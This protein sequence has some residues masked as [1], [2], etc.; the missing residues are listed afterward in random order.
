VA[1]SGL[2]ALIGVIAIGACLAGAAY[3]ATRHQTGGGGPDRKA[4]SGWLPKPAIDARPAAQSPSTSARFN[5][6]ARTPGARFE[7]RLDRAQWRACRPPAVFRGLTAGRHRFAVRAVDRQGRH[8]GQAG[9][10]WTILAA[11]DFSIDPSL[12]GLDH[13]YP[14]AEPIALPLTVTNPNPAPIFVTGLRVVVAADPAGC[15][16]DENLALVQSNASSASPL[17][18][19]ANGSVQLPAGRVLAP[20]IQLRDLPVNQDACKNARFPL[21][22][23]GVARG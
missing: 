11:K 16:S 3:A 17:K 13:L 5:F 6:T 9:V 7:C 8:G 1:R 20:T 10:R 18:V 21:G 4:R 14:G 2:R 22:F 12:S 19:P 23:S 15:S